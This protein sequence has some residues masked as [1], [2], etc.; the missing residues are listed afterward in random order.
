MFDITGKMIKTIVNEN[1][2]KGLHVINFDKSN[3]SAGNYFFT[4]SNG[5]GTET[6]KVVIVD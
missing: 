3:F 5:S 4:I 1:Q 6:K 2:S